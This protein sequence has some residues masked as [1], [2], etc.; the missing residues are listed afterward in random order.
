MSAA[1]TRRPE[2]YTVAISCPL[3]CNVL[4]RP[5]SLQIDQWIPFTTTPRHSLYSGR[6]I[7][8]RSESLRQDEAM[9]RWHTSLHLNWVFNQTLR[10]EGPNDVWNS[11]GRTCKELLP[12]AVE[13]CTAFGYRTFLD[14]YSTECWC[15]YVRVCFAWRTLDPAWTVAAQKYHVW[16]MHDR[17]IVNHGKLFSLRPEEMGAAPQRLCTNLFTSLWSTG[18]NKVGLNIS[19]LYPFRSMP[20]MFLGIRDS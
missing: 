17:I 4:A 6:D 18:I 9:T 5:R 14:R 7:P 10:C 16:S 19:S 3:T 15:T 20:R 13:G 8:G 2:K 12:A 1:K 11:W